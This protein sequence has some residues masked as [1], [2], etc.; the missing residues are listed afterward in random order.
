MLQAE[1]DAMSVKRGLE[2]Y[3]NV[4]ENSEGTENDP[5]GWGCQAVR[6]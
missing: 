4:R 1:A 3:E 5:D 2:G 6:R